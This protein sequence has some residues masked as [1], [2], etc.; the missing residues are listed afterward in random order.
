MYIR[1]DTVADGR[2]STKVADPWA[3]RWD[4]FQLDVGNA[5]R[6]PETAIKRKTYC[7]GIPGWL[8]LAIVC[9]PANAK[10]K[11]KFRSTVDD[12][13]TYDLCS[14]EVAQ[15]ASYTL[16]ASEYMMH[17]HEQCRTE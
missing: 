14:C 1:W 5:C 10:T 4:Y 16:H 3:N 13:K 7:N 11:K 8:A 6:E 2:K 12:L 15:L 9:K 17:V